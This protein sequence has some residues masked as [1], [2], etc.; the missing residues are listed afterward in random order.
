[1]KNKKSA[2]GKKHLAAKAEVDNFNS[3]PLCNLI[4]NIIWILIGVFTGAFLLWI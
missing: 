4:I 1:M 3:N 2:T